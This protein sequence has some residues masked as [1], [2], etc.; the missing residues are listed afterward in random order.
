MEDKKRR[1]YEPVEKEV[2][3]EIES[4]RICQEIY[5]HKISVA[6]LPKEDLNKESTNKDASI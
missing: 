4:P 2:C 1:V 3:C 6:W 5:T